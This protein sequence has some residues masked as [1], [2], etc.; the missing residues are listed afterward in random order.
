[1]ERLGAGRSAGSAAVAAAAKPAPSRT[2]FLQWVKTDPT[3][4][5]C[6]VA[7]KNFFGA[8]VQ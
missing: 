4:K 3:V 5:Q 7:T 8:K 1:V 6:L 2:F